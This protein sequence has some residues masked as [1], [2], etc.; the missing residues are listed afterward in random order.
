MSV[1][2][3]FPTQLRPFVGGAAELEFDGVSTLRDIVGRLQQDHPELAER[4]V[5]EKG[6]IRRFI[7]VYVGDEDVRFLD[8]LNTSLEGGEVVSVLPA[9]AGGSAEEIASPLAS[10]F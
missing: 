2:V 8:G 4:V 9:V 3:K 1:T 5:D 7:N 6:E 10:L